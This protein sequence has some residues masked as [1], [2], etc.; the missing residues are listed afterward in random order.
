[1]ALVSGLCRR[2][3]VSQF[4]RV[5]RR[6]RLRMGA[7]SSFDM[8]IFDWPA[9][10]DDDGELE[11]DKGRAKSDREVGKEG[12]EDIWLG[13]RMSPA[14]GGVGSRLLLADEV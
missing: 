6:G 10:T 8:P 2:A 4:M 14:A 1:M 12:R 13:W 3:S 7:E 5:G 11:P 9:P